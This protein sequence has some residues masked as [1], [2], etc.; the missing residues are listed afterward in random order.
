MC[1]F[2]VHPN[3]EYVLQLHFEQVH[4][5]DSP[6]VVKDDPEPLLQHE[7][8]S[9][10][11]HDSETPSSDEDESMVAC[12][13]PDCGELVPLLDFND[14]LDYHAAE[15]LSFDE[16]TGKYSSHHSKAAM[17]EQYSTSD[18]HASH[19]NHEFQTVTRKRHGRKKSQRGRSNTSSS[20][21]ST[22]SRTIDA[23]NPFNEKNNRPKPPNRN[24]R[25]GVSFDTLS[26]G[27]LLISNRKLS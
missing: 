13:E 25:L 24:G 6:F 10:R 12:P 21:K 27:H 22:L 14:H 2:T 9:K 7:L 3:D 1:D 17:Q 20:E 18:S 16:T 15:S 19:S 23:F 4:T 26:F 11:K 5:E 8:S